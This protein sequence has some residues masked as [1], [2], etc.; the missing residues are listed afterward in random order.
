MSISR[1]TVEPTGSA[2]RRAESPASRS[3]R[4]PTDAWFAILRARQLLVALTGCPP[5]SADE[6][7]RRVARD[8]DVHPAS[9]ADRLLHSVDSLDE[10]AE[11]FAGRVERT[12]LAA[13]LEGSWSAGTDRASQGCAVPIVSGDLRGVTVS[14]EIDAATTSLL[15]S[16][17][18]ESC[19]VAVGTGLW[20]RPVFLLNLADVTFLDASGLGALATTQVRAEAAGYRPRAAAPIAPGP[21]RVLRLAV[22]QGWLDPLFRPPDDGQSAV[23][24]DAW[25]AAR[26]DGQRRRGRLRETLSRRRTP[27]R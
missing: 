6:A 17:V 13:A 4:Q 26:S 1:R 18:V 14:G 21:R 25:A 22:D 23:D 2:D 8:L 24:G 27:R 19:S 15:D 20:S 12:A 16:A 5:E 9:V 11:R 10:D 3:R 7:L